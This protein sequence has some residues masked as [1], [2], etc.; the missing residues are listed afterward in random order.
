MRKGSYS[1]HKVF[2]GLYSD[3]KERPSA[4]YSIIYPATDTHISK[5][6]QQKRRMIAETPE[7]YNTVVLPY[8]NE[9]VGDRLTW[10]YNI[11]DHKAE[12]DRILYEDP[13]LVQGFVLLP[14]L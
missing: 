13:D 8:I 12:T 10:V 6:T 1:Q 11:L 9:M 7:L 3:A 4:K 14:D 2:V 5:Y